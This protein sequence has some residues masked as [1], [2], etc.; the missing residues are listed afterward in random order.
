MV[1][2]LFF[3]I[4]APDCKFK[5]VFNNMKCKQTDSKIIFEI[6]DKEFEKHL[7]ECS[8]CKELNSRVNDTMS[9]L[10]NTSDVPKGMVE[11]I[12]IKKRK[13]EIHKAKIWSLSSYMQ[14]AAVLLIAIFM[15]FMLGKNANTG[16][17]LSAES[18]K[19][20]SLIK[21]YETH[22]LDIEYSLVEL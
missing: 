17:L 15:G 4:L 14:I 11:A 6:L 20:K 2:F 21:Y 8:T 16:L 1:G 7:N 10:D 18:K 9:I 5:C 22:H 13:L 3:L 12:L 19:N